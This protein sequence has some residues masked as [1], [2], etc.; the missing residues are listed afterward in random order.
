MPNI[1]G[2]FVVTIHSGS[3]KFGKAE[4]SDD[5][6]TVGAQQVHCVLKMASERSSDATPGDVTL[7]MTSL[8][9]EPCETETSVPAEHSDEPVSNYDG[10]GQPHVGNVLRDG[11]RRRMKNKFHRPMRLSIAAQFTTSHKER[12]ARGAAPRET[13][14]PQ[15]RTAASKAVHTTSASCRRCVRIFCGV[16]PAPKPCGK[17]SYQLLW[18]MSGLFIALLKYVFAITC[19]LIIHDG[20]DVFEDTIGLGVNVQLMCMVVSQLLIAPFTAVGV[21][22]AGPDVIAA[23]FV[24][25]M[26]EIIEEETVSDPGQ[27]VPTLLVCMVLTSLLCGIT[28]LLIG[29]FDGTRIVDYVPVAVVYGFLGC[30][31]YKVLYYCIKVS[32]GHEWYNPGEWHFW[33]LLLPV[34]PLG[35]GLY[36]FKKYH[37]QLHC[38]PIVFLALFLIVPPMVVYFCMWGT[39]LDLQTMRDEGWLFGF[40]HGETLHPMEGSFFWFVTALHAQLLVCCSDS[41]AG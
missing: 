6:L 3:N 2:L 38:S 32:V 18:I 5:G 39:G 12:V 40:G 10:N 20:H 41:V 31:A 37:H 30:L 22:I 16:T 4:N 19:A 17:C 24:G 35:L 33:K 14:I 26:A 1:W 27:A 29:Y 23:I 28:W 7:E 9:P 13:V 8:A 11:V 36:Y 25:A 21:T 15:H 34:I